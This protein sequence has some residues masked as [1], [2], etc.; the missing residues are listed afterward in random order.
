MSFR[1]GGGIPPLHTS[2]SISL[3]SAVKGNNKQRLMHFDNSHLFYRH[4]IIHPCP[5]SLIGGVWPTD[6]LP[7]MVQ[8]FAWHI[9]LELFPHNFVCLLFCCIFIS[10][11]LTWNVF[12]LQFGV[13]RLVFSVLALGHHTSVGWTWMKW[14][15][16]AD[17]MAQLFV[18]ENYN[19]INGHIWWYFQY[20]TEKKLAKSRDHRLF[21]K[22]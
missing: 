4:S 13:C 6:H 15:L 20:Y 19:E 1:G 7:T 3:D 2:F 5:F 16:L 11:V 8:M 10:Y 14:P 9:E 21:N 22:I 18:F 12:G 17:S